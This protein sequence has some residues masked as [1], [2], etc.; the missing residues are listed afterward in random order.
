MVPRLSLSVTADRVNRTN[1]K[2]IENI[3]HFL[4]F[5][6]N[7]SFNI[8]IVKLHDHYELIHDVVKLLNLEWPRSESAR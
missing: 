7:D 8:E 4:S 1:G 2:K 5:G 6:M 3:K